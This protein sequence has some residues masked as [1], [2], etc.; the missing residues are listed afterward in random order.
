MEYRPIPDDHRDAFGRL[1]RYAFRPQAGPPDE[2]DE[3]DRPEHPDIYH[4]RALYDVDS[5]APDD[6]LDADDMVVVCA[7]YDFSLRVRGEF[8]RVG[9]VSAVASPPE[10]RRQ[11][12][13]GRLLRELHEELREEG[14]A[15]AALWP[16]KYS[17]YRRYGYAT[18]TEYAHAE[19][20]PD[21]LSA[22]VADPAGRFR[23]VD[24]DDW[25]DLAAVY[26]AW[27]PDSLAMDR[28]E[29][30]WRHRVLTGWQEDPYVYLWEDDDG[31]PR[32]YAVYRVQDG[33]DDGRTLQVW[34]F[35]HA[36]DEGRRQLYRFLRD[37]DSQVETV[38]FAGPTETYLL[39]TLED[40]R[41]AELEFRPGPMVRVVDLEAAVADLS[42]P[43]D[44]E[45]SVVLAVDDDHLPWNDG[46]F[47]LSV[48]GGGGTCEPTDAEADV[49][50]D[51][52]A[53]SQLVAGF[54]SVDRL[55]TY[56]DLTVV[57]ETGAETLA[58]MFPP[59][60][61]APFLREGF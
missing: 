36:D 16:F 23:R 61:P 28:T 1:L 48:A 57:S 35:A 42:F 44:A 54:L 41:A 45:G 19:I 10:I 34:E 6:D 53:L 9:G 59:E 12:H 37:H 55:E 24:P 49:E 2:E 7:Y 46:R 40:P 21:E 50:L 18:A 31:E 38:T 8:H 58:A 13:V 20:A 29:G 4:P 17:F 47:E 51:V 15:L 27:G 3:E 5:G 39:E 33:D 43:A 22:V 25:A 14:V 26:E 32:A 56:G 60:E 11:G 30:Y 52:G